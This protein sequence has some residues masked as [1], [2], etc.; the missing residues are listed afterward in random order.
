MFQILLAICLS[1]FGLTLLASDIPKG[2]NRTSSGD[3]CSQV[4][5]GGTLTNAL[6]L[7]GASGAAT[8]GPTAG[9]AA[10]TYNTV[11]GAMKFTSASMSSI[12]ARDRNNLGVNV[13]LDSAGALK[14]GS[15]QSGYTLLKMDKQTTSTAAV[16][17]VV[18]NSDSQTLD[19]SVVTTSDKTV[20]SITLG[21]A[22]TLGPSGTDNEH[23]FNG[24]TLN[25]G[26][27][28]YGS[29]GSHAGIWSTLQGASTTTCTTHCENE[30]TNN[31]FDNGSG[32][33]LA[34]WRVDTSV[35]IT[36]SDA[37]NIGKRCLCAGID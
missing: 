33:C 17:Q 3:Q 24:H 20:H 13:Y 12:F 21:G 11:N 5:V 22:H 6:C 18:S 26:R 28:L 19:S 37:T 10:G 7:D 36:C 29:S 30:D 16:W 8:I 9:L 2:R 25:T 15:S 23:V 27:G 34:A 4:N 1:I 14:A 35:D 31:S 32:V